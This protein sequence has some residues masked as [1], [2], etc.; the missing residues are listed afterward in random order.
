MRHGCQGAGTSVTIGR[1]GRSRGVR[2]RH[3]TRP[4]RILSQEVT[5]VD[6]AVLVDGRQLPHLVKLKINGN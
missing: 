1:S 2:L 3:K 4:F 5:V 6:V